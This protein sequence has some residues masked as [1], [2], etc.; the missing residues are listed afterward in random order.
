MNAGKHFLTFDHLKTIYY[1][2]IHPYLLY[3]NIIWGNTY[4]KYINKLVVLQKKAVRIM[5]GSAYN[6]H[7]APLFRESNILN[8]KDLHDQLVTGFMYDFVHQ[9]LPKSL[10]HIYTYPGIDHGHNTRHSIDPKIPK[11]QSELLKRSFVYR[12]PYLWMNMDDSIKTA[13][14]QQASKR[15]WQRN[16]LATYI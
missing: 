12:G 14:S 15:K 6:E 13:I 8:V 2:L 9:T 1:S 16:V 7:A 4:G 5:T 11:V 10:L 3:G